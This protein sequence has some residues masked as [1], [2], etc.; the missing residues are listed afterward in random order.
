MNASLSEMTPP[1]APAAGSRCVSCVDGASVEL[2][3]LADAADAAEA[4]APRAQPAPARRA[5]LSLKRKQSFSDN[6][7][8]SLQEFLDLEIDRV[9]AES[10]ADFQHAELIGDEIQLKLSIPV[11]KALSKELSMSSNF[12]ISAM[13]GDSIA[14][15]AAGLALPEAHEQPQPPR[16]K[17]APTMPDAECAECPS[18]AP[19]PPLTPPISPTPASALVASMFDGGASS[20]TGG[21][22]LLQR[23]V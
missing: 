8:P 22:L 16:K 23:E 11:P 5:E 19:S 15:L 20:R 10:S 2:T 18:L 17:H 14:E 3:A 1:T 4:A 21:F 13:G 6:L 12:S 9:L 7:P